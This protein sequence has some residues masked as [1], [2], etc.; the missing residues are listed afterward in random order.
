MPLRA[1][2]GIQRCV[3]TAESG[4]TNNPFLF[5]YL[6][7]GNEDLPSVHGTDHLLNS[8]ADSFGP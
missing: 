1:V 4:Y 6:F 2:L 5:P 8:A 3:S 7:V